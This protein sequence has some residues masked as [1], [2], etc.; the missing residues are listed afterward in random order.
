MVISD[1]MGIK[2]E[3]KT[4]LALL[5]KRIFFHGIIDRVSIFNTTNCKVRTRYLLLLVSSLVTLQ[6]A[7]LPSLVSSVSVSIIVDLKAG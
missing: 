6:S 5:F 4:L 1:S 3:A 7:S 2:L